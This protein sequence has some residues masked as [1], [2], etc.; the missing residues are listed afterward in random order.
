MKPRPPGSRGRFKAFVYLCWPPMAL[1]TALLGLWEG[2]WRAGMIHHVLFPGP[3][4]VAKAMVHLLSSPAFFKDYGVTLYEIAF[5]FMLGV[6]LGFTLGVLF[7]LLPKVR[8]IM[9][10]YMI[11]FQALPKIVLAPLFVVWF[12]F[13]PKSKVAMALAICF[14]P[15][16]I[17]TMLGFSQIDSDRLRVMRAL[18]ATRWQILTKLR[19]PGALPTVFAGIK[20]GLTL[21]IFG[22]IAAEFTGASAGVGTLVATYNGLIRVDYVLALVLTLVLLGWVAYSG[23]EMLDRRLTFWSDGAKHGR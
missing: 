19:L 15:V 1:L 20:T 2:L 12:G 10:P 14:F 6:T 11:A 22:T 8:S 9:Y 16:L 23:M 7:T 21:A 13:G 4:Q 17:N 5:G 3:S 18:L